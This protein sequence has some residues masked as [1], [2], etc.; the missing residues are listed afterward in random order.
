MYIAVLC[1]IDDVFISGS[2]STSLIDRQSILDTV[3]NQSI[4]LTPD[5]VDTLLNA[6]VNV[7]NVSIYQGLRVVLGI[8]I[9]RKDFLSVY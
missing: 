9:L 6:S 5:A 8:Y 2:I 7:Q 3:A 1:F 4:A